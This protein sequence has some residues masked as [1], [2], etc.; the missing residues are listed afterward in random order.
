MVEVVV[1]SMKRLA[2]AREY[3]FTGLLARPRKKGP[4]PKCEARIL[5]TTL[6]E[7]GQVVAGVGTDPD[8]TGFAGVRLSCAAF[9]SRCFLRK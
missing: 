3:G 5:A 9:L 8:C 2:M 7:G 6:G 1:A 4:A